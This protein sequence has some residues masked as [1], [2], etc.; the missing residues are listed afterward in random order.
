MRIIKKKAIEEQFA[1][2]PDVEGPLKAWLD[3]VFTANWANSGEVKDRYPGARPIANGR[4]VFKIKGNQYRLIVHI[5]YPARVVYIKFF[6]THAEY[7]KVDA[8]TV[9]DFSGL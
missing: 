1:R 6:G 8:S 9:D 4:V 2:Y 7:D 3:D 5:F